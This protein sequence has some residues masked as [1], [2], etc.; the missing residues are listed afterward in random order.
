MMDF[1][2]YVFAHSS[3]FLSVRV[4]IACISPYT[5]TQTWQG[6]VG[7]APVPFR[8][9]PVLAES[10][11][12]EKP[13]EP[14]RTRSQRHREHQGPLLLQDHRLGQTDEEGGAASLQA[15]LPQS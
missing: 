15:C 8:R 12:Q 1:I 10:A 11:V 13:S 14:A 2:H 9:G 7:H 5:Y 3:V 6:Q 4:F